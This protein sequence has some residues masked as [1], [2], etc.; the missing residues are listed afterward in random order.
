MDV[1][2][3]LPVQHGTPVYLTGNHASHLN[4]MGTVLVG[5][6]D[7]Q[8]PGL[9]AATSMWMGL[10]HLV[11]MSD[12]CEVPKIDARQTLGSMAE[13]D[14]RWQRLLDDPDCLFTPADVIETVYEQFLTDVVAVMAKHKCGFKEAVAMAETAPYGA[15]PGALS[16]GWSCFC[17]TSKRTRAVLPTDGEG[18]LTPRGTST[19]AGATQGRPASSNQYLPLCSP[20]FQQGGARP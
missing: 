14:D 6:P 12:G 10:F 1:V 17:G 15:A 8:A 7:L 9:Q 11:G 3:A 5:D 19:F 16:A 4:G 20:A 18:R 2:Q 13:V